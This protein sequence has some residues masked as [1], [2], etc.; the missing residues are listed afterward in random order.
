MKLKPAPYGV[1]LA[2][3]LLAAGC[4]R[5]DAATNVA[6][7]ATEMPAAAAAPAAPAGD[8]KLVVAFGD[9]LYAGYGVAQNESFPAELETALK[10]RG[11]AARVH[12]AGVSG[13]TTAAG[14]QRL[15]FALDGLPKKPELVIVGLGGN[16]ML[17][18]LPI[19]ETEKNLTAI[20]DELKRREIPAMLT[21]MLAAPNMGRDYVE[22][23]NDIYPALAKRYD[24]PLYPFFLEG[25][26]TDPK[27]MQPDRIHPTADGIDRIVARVTPVVEEALR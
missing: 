24:V 10:A 12:N 6:A 19:E 8:E 5:E 4:S 27:L 21:G 16:D 14:L 20:L 9:S 3:L 7:N 18:G 23:F 26:V 13:D 11:V 15:A 22:R 25:V 17:R 1:S 2:I